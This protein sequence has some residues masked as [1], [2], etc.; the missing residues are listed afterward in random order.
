MQQQDLDLIWKYIGQDRKLIIKGQRYIMASF[1]YGLI[2]LDL[3]IPR[4]EFKKLHEFC[5]RIA[6]RER[7]KS[8]AR[9]IIGKFGLKAH[10]QSTNQWWG[11]TEDVITFASFALKPSQLE[12]FT[13][14]LK[15]A[16]S[17]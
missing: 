17:L 3:S 14:E 8:L 13:T 16:V 12:S 10:F 7:M 2:P 1:E 15:K 6:N 11:S 4:S 5:T 9:P